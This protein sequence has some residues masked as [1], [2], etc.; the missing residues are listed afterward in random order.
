MFESLQEFYKN[1]KRTENEPCKRILGNTAKINAFANFYKENADE[2]AVFSAGSLVNY[3]NGQT[4]K[5][6]QESQA[7]RDGLAQ[8]PLFLEEC[9]K[10]LEQKRKD[11]ESLPTSD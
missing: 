7:F 8:L 3:L 11:E 1:Q 4:E 10:E 5:S 6:T 9:F 2:L